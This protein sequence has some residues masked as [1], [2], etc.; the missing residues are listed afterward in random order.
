[1]FCVYLATGYHFLARDVGFELSEDLR[2]R[3]FN[4]VVG[5]MHEVCASVCLTLSRRP[6]PHQANNTLT[7]SP[8]SFGPPL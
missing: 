4:V 2:V 7:T 3:V 8:V 6:T 1:M 5:F